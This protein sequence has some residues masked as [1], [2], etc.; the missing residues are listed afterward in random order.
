M[1]MLQGIPG[2]EGTVSNPERELLPGA[3]FSGTLVMDICISELEE[4]KFR[5]LPASSM[6]YF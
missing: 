4:N 2:E 5:L 6:W 3:G 1:H